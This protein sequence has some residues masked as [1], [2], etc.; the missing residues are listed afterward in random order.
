MPWSPIERICCFVNLAVRACQYGARLACAVRRN[1]VD[2][3]V[4]MLEDLKMWCCVG[5]EER[6]YLVFEVDCVYASL[7]LS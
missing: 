6:K 7:E 4:L 3:N 1:A 2:A 5:K